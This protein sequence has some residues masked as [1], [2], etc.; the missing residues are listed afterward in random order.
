MPHPDQVTVIDYDLVLAS[1][2]DITFSVWPHKG[3]IEDLSDP[4][5]L[6][7]TLRSGHVVSIRLDC[8]A[9]VSRHEHLVTLPAKKFEPST[10]A[11]PLVYP[12]TDVRH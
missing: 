8:L 10:A 11:T 6:R 3:D 1:G 2:R 7:L 4:T 9:V 12:P 5:M